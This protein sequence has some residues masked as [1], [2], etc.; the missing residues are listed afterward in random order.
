MKLLATIGRAALGLLA[1]IGRIAIFAGQTLGHIVRGPFYLRELAI[2]F[3]RIRR[4]DDDAMRQR[5]HRS[6]QRD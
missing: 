4:R 1:A 6:R 5:H 3:G 2:A